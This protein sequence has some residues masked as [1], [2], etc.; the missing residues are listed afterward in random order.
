MGTIILPV[1]LTKRKNSP[2]RRTGKMKFFQVPLSLVRFLSS[3]LVGSQL[4][5]EQGARCV[6]GLALLQA[7]QWADFPPF[8]G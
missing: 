2:D 6:M 7:L 3:G 4:S 8:C 1:V 5:G